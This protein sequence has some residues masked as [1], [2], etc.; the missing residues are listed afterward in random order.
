MRSFSSQ[1]FC[2][3][4]TYCSHYSRHSRIILKGFK[5]ILVRLIHGWRYRNLANLSYERLSNR[6]LSEPKNNGFFKSAPET[7]TVLLKS[8][9]NSTCSHTE[10]FDLT[11]DEARDRLKKFLDY[12]C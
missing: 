8:I 11:V 6:L 12:V 9:F 10:T 1:L 7:V 2:C 5:F 4:T 3:K